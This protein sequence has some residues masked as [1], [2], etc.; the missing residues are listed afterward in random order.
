M[1]IA[2]WDNEMGQVSMTYNAP[3]KKFL[4][5]V[6]DGWP[7]N[8]TMDTFILESDEITGPWKMLHYFDD[9]GPQAYSVSIP[10]R[11]ISSNG[12]RAWLCYGSNWSSFKDRLNPDH[13]KPRGSIYSMS[14]HET[15]L[16][17]SEASKETEN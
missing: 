1:F 4:M 10:S 13:G 17:P 8:K 2:E 3:L 15:L 9:F 6:T 12:H 16:N 14:L 11:F 7:G 5:C